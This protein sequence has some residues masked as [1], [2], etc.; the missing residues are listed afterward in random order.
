MTN[1]RIN[2]FEET[3]RQRMIPMDKNSNA[4]MSYYSCTFLSHDI[5]FIEQE[6]KE[7]V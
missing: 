7:K 6:M 2:S 3:P 4:H 1:N 5:M